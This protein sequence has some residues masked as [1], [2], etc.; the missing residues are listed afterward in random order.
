MQVCPHVPRGLQEEE[1][2]CHIR[3]RVPGPA[4]AKTHKMG[5]RI[6]QSRKDR[7]TREVIDGNVGQALEIR[8]RPDP[9][10]PPILDEDRPAEDRRA[11]CPVPH[12]C[13]AKQAA[14]S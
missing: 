13:A 11:P 10:D 9:T 4:V 6:N 3:K 8:D 1:F 5:V 12:A 7:C 14:S 2:R